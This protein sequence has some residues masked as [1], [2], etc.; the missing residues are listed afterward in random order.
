[1]TGEPGGLR[2]AW[3][4]PATGTRW[5]LYHDGGLSP[6]VG[7]AV[8]AAVAADEARWSR[9]RDDSEVNEIN[10]HAGQ[11]TL[12]SAETFALLDACRRWV[13][14]TRG[15]FTPLVGAALSAWGYRLSLEYGLAGDVTSPRAT[16]V[17]GAVEL[18]PAEMRV[19]L[20]A[21][22]RLDLGGIGK[23]WIA[24]RVAAL[25]TSLDPGHAVLVDAGGDL[26]AVDGRHL[27]AVES[28]RADGP[29]ILGF[30]P[31]S[32]GQ[33]IAT[34]G[35]SRRQWTNRDGT[36]AHH[37]IDPQTGAP[38]PRV[39][40]TVI[41]GDPVTADVTAK[42]LALRPGRL[43]ECSVPA[44]LQTDGGTVMSER[45]R[46]A[47]PVERPVG[48]QPPSAAAAS[49][50]CTELARLARISRIPA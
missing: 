44:L 46:F 16:K 40:A 10:R 9:F 38:G 50:S 19:R 18:D 39:H 47:E 2:P 45:W 36:Q 42:V 14:R 21:G 27:V 24:A 26:V 41:A 23:G 30:I 25:I 43:R 32:A 3:E 11:W 12:V 35:F 48:A 13:T 49:N 28:V 1:M 33:A 8:V 4:F 29:D 17:S 37:L 31:L 7:E 22:A 6:A 15:V 5:R 34:S 20:P